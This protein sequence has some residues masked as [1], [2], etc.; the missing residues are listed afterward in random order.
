MRAT[1]AILLGLLAFAVGGLLL[2]GHLWPQWESDLHQW[3]V[4]ATTGQMVGGVIGGLL[5]ILPLMQALRW[6]REWRR[7][8]EISY[9]TDHGRITVSLIAIE[10]A[11]TRALEGEPEVKRATV[12]VY[13]DRAKRAVVIE[14]RI[15]L[16]EVENLTERNRFCQRLLRRRFAELMPE[17]T[18]VQVLITIHRIYQRKADD[19]VV[20]QTKGSARLLVPT[21]A[22]VAPRAV[23]ADDIYLPDMDDSADEDDLYHGPS[24]PVISDE[25]E[26]NA[27]TSLYGRQS[28]V[29]NPVMPPRR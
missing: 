7:S 13:E 5:M 25:D 14:A 29:E 8:R 28:S 12:H 16:W 11:L 22:A 6:W 26:D 2:S 18:T 17:Q 10:E 21:A 1:L 9:T 20:G 19:P 3:V 27:A 24:Y 23:K 4:T 15:T